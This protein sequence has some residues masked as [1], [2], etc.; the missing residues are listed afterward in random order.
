VVLDREPPSATIRFGESLELDP[1]A[2]ELRRDG[3]DDPVR[4]AV[5]SFW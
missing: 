4:Q 2:W 5:V 1:E 3:R